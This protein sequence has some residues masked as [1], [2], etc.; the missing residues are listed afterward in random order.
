M[1][2]NHNLRLSDYRNIKRQSKI[3]LKIKFSNACHK[4]FA[5]VDSMGNVRGYLSDELVH[6]TLDQL[7]HGHLKN[8][9]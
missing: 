3:K 4:I 8:S 1:G 9:R 7:N 2:T 6:I 5:D